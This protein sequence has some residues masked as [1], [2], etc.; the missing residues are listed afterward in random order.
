MLNNSIDRIVKDKLSGIEKQPPDYVW[1]AINQRMIEAK[2]KKRVLI[3]WQSVAAI[4]LL[5]LSVGAV[6][7]FSVSNTENNAQIALVKEPVVEKPENDLYQNNN[8][9]N[10]TAGQTDSNDA[11]IKTVRKSGPKPDVQKQNII[12]AEEGSSGNKTLKNAGTVLSEGENVTKTYHQNDNS[13]RN[14][15]LAVVPDVLSKKLEP[16]TFENELPSTDLKIIGKKKSYRPLYAYSEPV[17]LTI[18]KKQDMKFVLTGSA[19][20]TYNYRG[21]GENQNSSVVYAASDGPINENGIV[22]VAG[23]INVRLEGRSRWSIETGV[24]YSQVGQ[25]VSQ[26]EMFYK[27]VAAPGSAPESFAASMNDVSSVSVSSL[28]NNLGKIRFND[29]SPADV[30]NNLR[31]SGVYMVSSNIMFDSPSR[32]ATLKQTLDYIEIPLT[33]RYAI[34][35]KKPIISLAGGFSTNFLVDNTATLY[36]NGEAIKKGETDGINIVTYSSTVGLGVALP[37]GRSFRINLEPMF[38]YFLS[39]VNNS[40]VRNYHP[41]SFGVFGGVSFILNNH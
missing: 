2:S 32:A 40:G 27:S 1:S 23:G 29:I 33:V 41:Y 31:K 21:L 15:Q 13:D 38:K 16:L 28:S 11:V 36:E 9:E 22:S 25:E 19:S 12:A 6:Y 8:T 4:A 20:P 37:L 17:V 30:E 26:Q 35:N 10:L 14:I 5:L 39:P 24:L 18:P 7:F 3:F 34:L